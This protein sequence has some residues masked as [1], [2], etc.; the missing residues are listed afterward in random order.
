[1]VV[2]KLIPGNSSN[3]GNGEANKLGKLGFKLPLSS[4][5]GYTYTASKDPASTLTT[6][7]PEDWWEKYSPL[8]YKRLK[9]TFRPNPRELALTR[10]I[11]GKLIAVKSGHSDFKKYHI[12][13]HHHSFDSC[14]CGL[15]KNLKHFYFCRITRYRAHKAAGNRRTKDAIG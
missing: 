1:M 10:N 15:P 7:Y 13:F 8:R 9:I 11:L 12:R 5:H 3:V 4:R 2:C 14:Q 6:Q